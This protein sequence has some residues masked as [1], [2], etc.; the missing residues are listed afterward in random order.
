MFRRLAAVGLA[1]LV[2]LGTLLSAS[3]AAASTPGVELSSDGVHYSAT[4]SGSLFASAALMVPQSTQ[5]GEFWVR[6]ASSEPAYLRISLSGLTG[7][8]TAFSHAL[9]VSASTTGGAGTPVALDAAAPCYVL[10][11]GQLL[12]PGASVKVTAQLSM[13]DLTGLTGQ[14]ATTGFDVIVGL[15]DAAYGSVPPTTCP[16]HSGIV[17]GT[18]GGAGTGA[19]T[20]NTGHQTSG[21]SGVGPATENAVSGTGTGDLA[22]D[23]PEGSGFEGAGAGILDRNTGR[24]FQEW[25]VMLWLLGVAVGGIAR[26]IWERLYGFGERKDVDHG[27][28]TLDRP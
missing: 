8:G 1:A 25:F 24:F 14:H 13:A 5:T 4:Y 28:Q 7:G 16:S 21:G 11:Q 27:W 26:L 6:N 17:P 22:T 15:S 3:P 10:T 9:T 23:T 20:G 19:T 2:V 12:N 18:S